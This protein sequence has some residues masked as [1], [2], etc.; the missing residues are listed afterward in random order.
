M[1]AEG[2]WSPL[3]GRVDGFEW[4]CRGAAEGA[5]GAPAAITTLKHHSRPLKPSPRHS[6]NEGS[7]LR[8]TGQW[9]ARQASDWWNHLEHL[10]NGESVDD[11]RACEM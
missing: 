10:P 6:S 4:G 5:R 3:W 8:T 7:G 9:G 2:G 1:G 11:L